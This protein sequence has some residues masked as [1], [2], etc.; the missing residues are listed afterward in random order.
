MTKNICNGLYANML[1]WAYRGVL[2]FMKDSVPTP[3]EM[4]FVI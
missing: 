2:A 3:M 1:V 4:H